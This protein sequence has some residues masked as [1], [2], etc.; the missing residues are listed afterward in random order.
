[1]PALRLLHGATNGSVLIEGDRIA[2]A[3]E[4]STFDVPEDTQT[5]DCTGATILPGFWNAHVHFFERKWSDASSI[6]APELTAQLEDFTRYGFTTVFDLSSLQ[7]NTRV[8]QSRVASG[9]LAGPRILST[10]EGLVA[11]GSLPPSVVMTVM[12]VMPTPMPEVGDAQM[13]RRAVRSLLDAGADAIK[14]FLSSNSGYAVVGLDVLRAIVEESHRARKKVFVH[15]NT[16]D[17]VRS[18]LR[19][20]VDVLAH[21]TPRGAWD[22]EILEAARERRTALI[23]TLALWKHLMQHDRTSLRDA[24]VDTA[25]E[26]LR[27][28]REAGGIVLFGTD[29]GAIGADPGDEYALMRKAGMD[30]DAILASMTSTP[31]DFFGE[32]DRGRIAPNYVADLVVVVGAPLRPARMTIR[33][34]KAIYATDDELREGATRPAGI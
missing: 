11:P 27:M 33:S 4:V 5:I 21:T 32:S 29:Y 34:G 13:A 28:W 1:V 2:R 26:Q 24:M 22:D 20:G 12:G 14:V 30:A 8:L 6:P 15:P 31:A 25:I 19:A 17:D 18:A 16:P 3:G 10:G 9:E 23:P 7:N